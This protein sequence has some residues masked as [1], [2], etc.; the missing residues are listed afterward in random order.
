[1]ESDDADGRPERRGPPHAEEAGSAEVCAERYWLRSGTSTEA[2]QTK[3]GGS[4][5]GLRPFRLACLV[6]DKGLGF[7]SA[8]DGNS[9]EGFG[10]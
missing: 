4:S 5:L 9:L 10:T 8:C 2:G 3:V 6:Y 1:M 7:Y